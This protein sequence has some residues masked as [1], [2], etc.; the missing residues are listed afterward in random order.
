MAF[1]SLSPNNDRGWL[2]GYMGKHLIR[3]KFTRWYSLQPPNPHLVLKLEKRLQ[4]EPRSDRQTVV[5]QVSAKHTVSV[6]IWGCLSSDD[7]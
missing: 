5:E 1:Q 3:V 2:R 4:A 7:I 6:V